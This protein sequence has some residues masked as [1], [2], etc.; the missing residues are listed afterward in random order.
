MGEDQTETAAFGVNADGTGTPVSVFYQILEGLTSAASSFITPMT[1]RGKLL[2][3]DMVAASQALSD[4]NLA[5]DRTIVSYAVSGSGGVLA[6]WVFKNSYTNDA[7]LLTVSTSRFMPRQA[8]MTL[9]IKAPAVPAS[10]IIGAL[11]PFGANPLGNFRYLGQG[12][13]G[14]VY[15]LEYTG[16]SND[17][18]LD[19][20]PAANE[21]I[22][23]G[24]LYWPSRSQFYGSTGG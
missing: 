21:I 6:D 23:F 14:A 18:N 15:V 4:S 22:K 20:L 16:A 1:Q 3:T 10:T 13:T 17:W 8:Y 2:F 5:L 7:G 24:T 11:S 12:S 9:N 19:R